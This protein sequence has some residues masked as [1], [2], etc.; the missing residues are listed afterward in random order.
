MGKGNIKE[1][2]YN[3]KLLFKGEIVNGERNGKEKEKE[4]NMKM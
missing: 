2:D 1:Y 4:K 3:D